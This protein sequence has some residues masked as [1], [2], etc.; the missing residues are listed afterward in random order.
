MQTRRD[1]VLKSIRFEGPDY[2]PMSFHINAA[3]WFHYDQNA[4]LDLMEAHPF[5]FPG[6][7]RPNLP[8]RPVLA[9]N[10]RAGEDFVDDW[11][12]VW[13][14]TDDGITGT[15]V[16]HPLESWDAFDDYTPPDPETVSGIG[17][18]DWEAEAERLRSAKERGEVAAGGL[19]H[20]HTFL[21]LSDIRGYEGL[22]YDMADD[23]PR[24]HRLIEMV[25]AFNTAVIRKY[26]ALGA[27][28]LSYPEDLG[29]QN[30]P[31]LAPEHFR[32]Y[33]QPVYRRM[34][35]PAK[36]AGALIHMHS[37]GDI[38]DLMDDILACG[39]DA[40]NLQDLVNGID[41]IRTHLAGK[42]CVDLDIDRQRVTRFG[43]AAQIDELIRREVAELGSPQGGLMMIFGLYPGTPLENVGAL[44]DAM[45][46]YAGFHQG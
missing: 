38:R 7:S 46:R 26:V 31:M 36:E 27:E 11:G 14:T 25:E 3:C 21:Q 35:E 18:V 2:V 16:G 10:A 42:V 1:A 12:C 28:L 22:I 4:L 29:M 24:L 39:V 30:G 45:E 6:F 17:P 34:M 37:D 8:Y 33:I 44:M 20:G 23:E 13:R 19:R 15:V 43:T 9:G 40:M 41:W 5:L 32:R